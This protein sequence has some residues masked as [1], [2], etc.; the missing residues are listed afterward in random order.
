M[1]RLIDA[2][3]MLRIYA[4]SHPKIK[5]ELS[6]VDPILT[7]NNG[8]YYINNGVLDKKNSIGSNVVDIEQLTQALFGYHTEMLPEKLKIFNNQAAFMSLMLD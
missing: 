7:E 2:E 4:I 5:M 8:T 3:T 6:L 1:S